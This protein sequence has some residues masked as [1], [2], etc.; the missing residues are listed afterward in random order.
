VPWLHTA[1]LRAS[2]SSDPDSKVAVQIVLSQKSVENERERCVRKICLSDI[3]SRE[4]DYSE[5]WG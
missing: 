4:S 2:P 5:E 3:L 1:S